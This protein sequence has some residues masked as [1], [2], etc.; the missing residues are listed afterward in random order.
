LSGGR[1]PR[2]EPSTYSPFAF[3]VAWGEFGGVGGAAAHSG[4]F[5][6]LGTADY[7]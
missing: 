7:N 6:K 1:I 3:V 2:A 5:I 4:A